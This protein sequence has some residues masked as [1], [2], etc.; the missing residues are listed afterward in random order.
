MRIALITLPLALSLLVGC[1]APLQT[2]FTFTKPELQQK[3]KKAFPLEKQ[4]LI[5][6][7]SLNDPE[8][9]LN[10][11]SDRIGL[12]MTA[13]ANIGPLAFPGRIDLDG[14]LRYDGPSG[15]FFLDEPTVTKMDF[16]N[17]PKDQEP[18]IRE[19]ATAILRATLPSVPLYKLETK[20]EKTAKLLIR[21]VQVKEGKLLVDMG[22]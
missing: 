7:L 9:L 1:P 19:A 12:G 15:A 11:S 17:L 3:I 21:K 20:T 18:T 4:I 6:K 2:R 5:A 14:K 13:S 10:P 8:V 16:E 22:L